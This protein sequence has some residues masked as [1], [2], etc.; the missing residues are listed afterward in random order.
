MTD[1]RLHAVLEDLAIESA[2][3]DALVADRPEEDWRLPTPAEGWDVATSIAHLAWTDEVAVLAATDKAG[4]DEVVL[5][6]IADPTGFVDASALAAGAVPPE[7]LLGRWRIARARLAEVLETHPAGEKLPWFGPPM[8]PTSMATAR[9]METWAHGLDVADALGAT[10][11]PHDR[12]RHV[13]HIGVRTR[14]FSFAGNGLDV[15]VGEVRVELTA[16]GGATW[17]YGPEDADQRVTGSAWDFALLVTQRR[18][19]ADLDLVA[20]GADADRWLDVAQAFAGP[21]GTGRAPSS[22]EPD[23]PVVEPDSPVVEP[24]ETAP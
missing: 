9:Y 24:V 16:P 7:E 2:G 23:S 3:L 1:P 20:Q 19:R 4:W 17:G 21:S 22:V 10:V 5:E 11:A 8:S 6:A 15:P 12:V 14:A 13:V 18:H